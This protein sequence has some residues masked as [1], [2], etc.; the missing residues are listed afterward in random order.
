[1]LTDFQAQ[2]REMHESLHQATSQLAACVDTLHAL[3]IKFHRDRQS[4]TS[5]LLAPLRLVLPL[6]LKQVMHI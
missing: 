3:G 6:H 4:S 5:P 1:M 2:K